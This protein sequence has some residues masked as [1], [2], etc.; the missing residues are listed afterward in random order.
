MPLIKTETQLR[1][2]AIKYLEHKSA[3]VSCFNE[4]LEAAVPQFEPKGKTEIYI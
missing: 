1:E 3:E 4:G 2:R